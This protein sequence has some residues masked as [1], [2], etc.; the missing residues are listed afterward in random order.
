[1]PKRILIVDDQRHVR[2]LLESALEP[3]LDLGVELAVSESGTE[4]IAAAEERAPDLAL[5]DWN[6]PGVSGLQVCA[7]LRRLEPL[8]PTYIIVLGEKGRESER[9]EALAA[10]ADDFA[11]K[12]FDPD[13]VLDRVAGALGLEPCL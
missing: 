1:M 12:P 4:A 8:Q 13:D 5:V 11:V 6:M 3:L 10:G 9:L 7:A 2:T